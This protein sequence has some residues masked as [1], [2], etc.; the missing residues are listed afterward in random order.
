M[1][2]GAAK[3]SRDAAPLVK[4]IKRAK[5]AID[6]D[7]ELIKSADDLKVVRAVSTVRKVQYVRGPLVL[8]YST[9]AS[10]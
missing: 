6:L 5:K 10:N 1:A 7:A 9:S 3:D 8:A 4:P 2:I